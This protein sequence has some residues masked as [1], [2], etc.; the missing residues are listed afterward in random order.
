MK[1][2]EMAKD[3]ADFVQWGVGKSE[4]SFSYSVISSVKKLNIFGVLGKGQNYRVLVNFGSMKGVLPEQDLNEF[5]DVLNQFPNVNMPPS[6]VSEG[7][8]PS[9]SVTCLGNEKNLEEFMNGVRHLQAL[10]R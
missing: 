6:Y 7:K 1:L 3:E 10:T 5:L 2:L 4:G 8:Y 9:F